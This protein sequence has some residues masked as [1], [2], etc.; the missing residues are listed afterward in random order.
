MGHLLGFC[1]FPVFQLE[2]EEEQPDM[3]QPYLPH[4][5]CAC[6]AAAKPAPLHLLS[7]ESA[8]PAVFS[9][10]SA[11]ISVRLL[12]LLSLWKHVYP[13]VMKECANVLQ[14]S[15]V[16]STGAL[17]LLLHVPH[18]AFQYYPP[19]LPSF[20][21]WYRWQTESPIRSM[22]RMAVIV[23]E[24]CDQSPSCCRASPSMTLRAH[25]KAQCGRASNFHHG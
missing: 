22:A 12:H 8:V 16:R 19:S 3:F 6:G 4:A 9:T 1:F 10:G 15:L 17:Q 7:A 18:A 2:A 21:S 13:A 23:I 11:G 25:A 5:D 20:F 14:P 24:S